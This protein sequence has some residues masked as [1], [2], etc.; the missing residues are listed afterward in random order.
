MTYG[1]VIYTSTGT[2]TGGSSTVLTTGGA[3]YYTTNWSSANIPAPLSVGHSGKLAISGIDADIVIN[4]ESLTGRLNTF[5]E[6]LKEIQDALLIPG[7]LNRPQELEE[8]FDELK[9][10]AE[11]YQLKVKEF[12]EKKRAWNILKQS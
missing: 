1:N 7:T 5:S 3:P 12:Q 9:E 8:N 11:Q 6:Q 2:G 4:G 10:L